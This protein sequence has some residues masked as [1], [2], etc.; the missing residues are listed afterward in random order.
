MMNQ[1]EEYAIEV[2]GIYLKYP[3]FN[4]MTIQEMLSAKT[5]RMKKKNE[6]EALKDVSFK[7]KKGDIVGIIGKNGSGKSTLLSTLAGIFA[8]DAGTIDTHGYSVSLLSIGTGFN[9]EMSGRENI[10][11]SGMLLGFER[12]EILELEDSI[13]QFA[14]IGEFI[15]LPV[16]KYS[17]GM[18]SKLAFSIAV[19]LKTDIMLVDEVLSVG[20]ENFKQKS[21]LKMQE[22]INEDNR[23]VLIVS[24]SLST[25]VELCDSILWLHQGEVVKMGEPEAILE[26]YKAFMSGKK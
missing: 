2:E 19:T 23:T 13:I 18:Y 1:K 15:D 9:T 26:E 16:K 24:H 4:R 12:E 20:D 17:S 10:F 3:L 7:V 21:F 22:L 8:P 5:L 11:L 25:L 6:F 14:D